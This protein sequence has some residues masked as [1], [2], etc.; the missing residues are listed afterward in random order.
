MEKIFYT[1]D[2]VQKVLSIGRN[3][4]YQYCEDGTIPAVRLGK[5]WR[6]P[7]KALHEQFEIQ[8]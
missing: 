4:A 7:I 5:Q 3:K 1:V 8:E 2:E 6:V